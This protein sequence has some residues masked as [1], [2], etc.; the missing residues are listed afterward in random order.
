MSHTGLYD[1][2]DYSEFL[3]GPI[4]G[5]ESSSSAS[6]AACGAASLASPSSHVTTR[7]TTKKLNKIITTSSKVKKLQKLENQGCA[8]GLGV[9]GYREHGSSYYGLTVLLLARLGLDVGTSL[10]GY[11]SLNALSSVQDLK[12]F[13][14]FAR[15]VR[16]RIKGKISSFLYYNPYHKVASST[17]W[18]WGE[19]VLYQKWNRA[20]FERAVS[21]G[22]LLAVAGVFC[23]ILGS[24][25]SDQLKQQ[26]AGGGGK[27]GKGK[28]GKGAKGKGKGKK[29]K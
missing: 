29:K 28:K 27:K 19:P 14:R 20:Q 4:V 16:R 6:G 13:A 22:I 21:T 7:T 5:V 23:F 24:F 9:S 15:I 11:N 26:S 12:D 3:C 18:S 25:I 8:G 2:N 10:E 17:W 1:K